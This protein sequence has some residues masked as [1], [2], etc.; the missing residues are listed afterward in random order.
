[1]GLAQTKLLIGRLSNSS[2]GIEIIAYARGTGPT[3]LIDPA[4]ILAEM[5]L[6]KDE[7]E[8][9]QIC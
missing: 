3:I 8:L 7:T 6:V 5:R 1:M 9:E 4:E 2:S